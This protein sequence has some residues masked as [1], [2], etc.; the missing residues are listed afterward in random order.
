MPMVDW[1]CVFVLYVPDSKDEL[2]L[3]VLTLVAGQNIM[4]K[5][6]AQAVNSPNSVHIIQPKCKIG[7]CILIKKKVLCVIEK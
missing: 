3:F 5:E 7:P 6:V 4:D 2:L 1:I